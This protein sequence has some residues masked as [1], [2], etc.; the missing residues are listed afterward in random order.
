MPEKKRPGRPVDRVRRNNSSGMAK[1]GSGK[2]AF[3]C[4]NGRTVVRRAFATSPLRLLM[5]RNHGDAAWVFTSTFGG[6]LV[7]GDRTHLEVDVG[8]SAKAVLLTQASTKVYRS[9]RN[10]RQELRARVGQAG[11]L[12]VLPDPVS[13]FASSQFTQRQVYELAADANL[14][15]VD[16]L[17]AGRWAAGERWKGGR[18]LSRIAIRR[19]TRPLLDEALLLDPADGEIAERMGRFNVLAM[20]VLTGPALAAASERMLKTVSASALRLRAEP[21]FSASALPDHG[22]AL[23]RVA[24]VSVE[25]AGLVLRRFLDFLSGLLGEDPWARK[26]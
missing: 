2:L 19:D 17:T 12:A 10:A 26:W 6:G 11:L 7:G 23:L 4:V 24:A 18:F 16:G 14:V 21:I 13:C 15:V 9:P 20:A 5:P 8:A 3:A 22:G 1:P 25:E